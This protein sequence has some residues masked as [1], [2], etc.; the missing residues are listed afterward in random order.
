MGAGFAPAP[1]YSRTRRWLRFAA[2]GYADAL[3]REPGRR[4]PDGDPL[5]EDVCAYW[6]GWDSGVQDRAAAF[7]RAWRRAT[8][9]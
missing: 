4:C 8:C 2:P 1:D 9:N 5:A 3:E 7:F 6:D